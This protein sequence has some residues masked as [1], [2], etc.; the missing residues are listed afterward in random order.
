MARSKQKEEIVVEWEPVA[1]EGRC[2]EKGS[3][4]F[5]LCVQLEGGGRKMDAL[6]N[7]SFSASR[8]D[9]IPLIICPSEQMTGIYSMAGP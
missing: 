2:V 1:E 6:R 3:L 9:V 8:Q 4:M 5:V 7:F